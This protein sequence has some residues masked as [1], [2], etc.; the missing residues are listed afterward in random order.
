MRVTTLTGAALGNKNF[1]NHL[2]TLEKNGL[3][4]D[5]QNACVMA[6]M[7]ATTERMMALMTA[8]FV[9]S[10]VRTLFISKLGSS[11]ARLIVPFVTKRKYTLGLEKKNS[12]SLSCD[13]HRN[14]RMGQCCCVRRKTNGSAE[15]K[16][17]PPPPQ[18]HEWQLHVYPKKSK[19]TTTIVQPE[20]KYR[21]LRILDGD[22]FD[23]F[24]DVDGA[25]TIVRVRIARVDA[26]EVRPKLDDPLHDKHKQCGQLVTN[27]ALEQLAD[28]L[29]TLEQLPT[30]DKWPGR[31]DCEVFLPDGRNFSNVLLEKKLV[32]LM[33]AR[34][35]RYPW[36]EAEF[37]NILKD[38]Q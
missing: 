26:P 18:A 36:T 8:S 14:W 38:L 21:L 25:D 30:P 34:G 23:C 22:T 28:Q 5:S 16:P 17:P 2:K 11:T 24:P 4:V 19:P 10:P 29:L 13:K 3:M 33:G 32:K 15:I 27:Y 9:G 1:F 35:R 7:D 6:I 31:V 20:K 12:L 37:D